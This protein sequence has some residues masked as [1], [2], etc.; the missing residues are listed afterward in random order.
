MFVHTTKDDLIIDNKKIL[1]ND[2]A[3]I[4]FK[5]DNNGMGFIEILFNGRTPTTILLD[6]LNIKDIRHIKLN[7]IQ[8]LGDN[9]VNSFYALGNK[10]INLGNVTRIQSY[11]NSAIGKEYVI[12][13]DFTNYSHKFTTSKISAERVVREFNNRY[14]RYESMGL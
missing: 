4:D 6:K 7:L 13:L 12:I 14:D 9:G 1:L 10:L 5:F 8:S 11:K 3:I 2:V